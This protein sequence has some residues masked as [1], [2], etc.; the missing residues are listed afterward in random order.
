MERTCCESYL[1]D[2]TICKDQKAI[3]YSHLFRPHRFG[4]STLYLTNMPRFYK[5]SGDKAHNSH[6]EIKTTHSTM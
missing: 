2:Q 4:E 5:I 6:T 1:T 3:Y